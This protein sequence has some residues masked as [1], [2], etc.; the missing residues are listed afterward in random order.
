MVWLSDREKVLW[1]WLLIWIQ[2]TNVTGGQTDGQTDTTR[3]IASCGKNSIYYKKFIISIRGRLAGILYRLSRAKTQVSRKLKETK[4]R[5]KL[6]PDSGSLLFCIIKTRIVD[7][8]F[9]VVT[10]YNQF[11]ILLRICKGMDGILCR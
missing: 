6:N 2:Y 11:K 10:C 7:I 3:R 5:N 4:S 9:W 1:M 8:F